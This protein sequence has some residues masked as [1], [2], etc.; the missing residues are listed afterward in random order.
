M[1]VPRVP[2]EDA[3]TP[4]EMQS[5]CVAAEQE[6]HLS[7]LPPPRQPGRLPHPSPPHPSPP[8][9]APVVSDDMAA[10]AAGM[11]LHLD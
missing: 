1:T 7:P 9:Q 6:L 10:R 11:E 8:F 3:A 4:A 2:Y 5:D